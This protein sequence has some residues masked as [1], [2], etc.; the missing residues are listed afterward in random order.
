MNDYLNGMEI[1]LKLKSIFRC[2]YNYLT[3]KMKLMDHE[4][5]T[6]ITVIL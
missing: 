3:Y 4:G 6:V 2:Y 1:Y 5:D